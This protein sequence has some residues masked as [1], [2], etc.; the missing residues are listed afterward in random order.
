MEE[1]EAIFW[2]DEENGQLVFED[3]EGENRF[4][5]DETLEIDDTK[6]Y[7]IVPVEEREKGKHPDEE[8]GFIIK[9]MKIDNRDVL[10]F[11]ED[12]DEFEKVQEFYMANKD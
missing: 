11:I 8:E 4:F 12:D 3:Q 5:L 6:Y 1:K 10:T 7:I 9:L 2:V